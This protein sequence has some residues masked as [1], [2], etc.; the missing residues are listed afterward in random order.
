MRIDGAVNY[1]SFMQHYNPLD[2]RPV[3]DPSSQQVSE[4][5]KAVSGVGQANAVQTVSTKS[6]GKVSGLYA[7]GSVVSGRSPYKN[8]AVQDIEVDFGS[9]LELGGIKSNDSA[10]SASAMSKDSMLQDYQY[11]VGGRREETLVDNS[12][13]TVLKLG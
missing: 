3:Q 4:D 5:K 11:F 7:D 6:E 10:A 2:V 1:S 9:G 12:D 8:T 13:G